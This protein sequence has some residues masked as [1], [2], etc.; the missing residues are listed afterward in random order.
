MARRWLG[1][2]DESAR[3]R[4][5]QSQLGYVRTVARRSRRSGLAIDELLAE[6]SLGLIR[7]ANKFDPD[8]GYRFFTY[9]KHWVHVYVS[10]CVSRHSRVTL[11][12][13]RLLSKATRERA[14]AFSLVGEG[15][16]ARQLIAERMTLGIDE[17][18]A[19]LC[20][21]DQREVSFEALAPEQIA[22]D[23][24][25]REEEVDPEQLLLRRAD[26]VQRE[27]MVRE[28]LGTL[29]ARE[30]CIVARRLMADSDS[31][32]TLEQLGDEFGVS[33]ERIRQL[34]KR[35]K[36]KLARRFRAPADLV[37]SAPELAA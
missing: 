35:I 18:E 32:L 20:T 2:G 21:I 23:S 19:L 29:D 3:N 26:R 37:R 1:M 28:M 17:V 30:R 33:R 4:L 11:Q 24:E 22:S 10:N 31:M 8:R 16:A 15:L 7:A 34:E 36:Q 9:A 14:R 25:P 12:R 13:T 27:S 6:G 5:V